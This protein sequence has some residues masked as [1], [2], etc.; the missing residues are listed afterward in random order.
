MSARA[1]LMLSLMLSPIV[2]GCGLEEEAPPS[3][4][5]P[6]TEPTPG[7]GT[8]LPPLVYD[9]MAISENEWLHPAD[10]RPVQGSQG[11]I[12]PCRPAATSPH[13][14]ALIRPGDRF[15]RA[16][17]MPACREGASPAATPPRTLPPPETL[18]GIPPTAPER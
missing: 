5:T 6:T 10:K 12:T 13:Q 16:Q 15:A 1:M 4:P 9:G 17:L 14:P 11:D 7:T 8:Q 18:E 2:A 3:G